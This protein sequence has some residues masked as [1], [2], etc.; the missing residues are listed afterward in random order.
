MFRFVLIASALLG[1]VSQVH[2][3]IILPGDLN[4][5]DPFR[6]LITTS[7]TT[8]AYATSID[9]YDQHVQNAVAN[10][11]L[12]GFPAGD[13]QVLGSTFGTSARDHTNTNPTVNVGVPI[14]RPDG[15]R[16]ADDY[17]ELWSGNLQAAPNIT[18]LGMI[19]THTA[20]WTGSYVNGT[21]ANWELGNRGVV[22]T[23]Q[24]ANA[25]RYGRWFHHGN[26]WQW[27]ELPLYGISPVL[28]HSGGSTDPDPATVPEPSTF[29]MMTIG[30]A[31]LYISQ[32]RRRNQCS[33]DLSPAVDS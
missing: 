28:T 32:R 7:T 18:E 29:L 6:V 5:G 11:P 13:W 20:V 21:E 24:N 12:L 33:S 8:Q 25:H 16:L 17:V 1:I 26:Q 23:G 14:Y 31:G 2:A 10:S 30:M 9:Y 4:P 22:N 27:Y 19:S 15:V 3:G